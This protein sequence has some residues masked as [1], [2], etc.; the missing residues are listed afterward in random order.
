MISSE[1]DQVTSVTFNSDTVKASPEGGI[2]ALLLELID[3]VASYTDC[4]DLTV[5]NFMY[6]N[7]EDSKM[8]AALAKAKC[9]IFK[10][11]EFL[12]CRGRFH[13]KR[14]TLSHEEI[15]AKDSPDFKENDFVAEL[16]RLVAC[17]ILAV[18]KGLPLIMLNLEVSEANAIASSLTKKTCRHVYWYKKGSPENNFGLVSHHTHEIIIKNF[19]TA[20]VTATV[21]SIAAGLEPYNEMHY[22]SD[23]AAIG[24]DV[25]MSN[26]GVGVLASFNNQ[27]LVLA[28]SFGSDSKLNDFTRGL[29]AKNYLRLLA[30][31]DMSGDEYLADITKATHIAI[32]GGALGAA[33]GAYRLGRYCG[34]VMSNFNISSILEV[35]PTRLKKIITGYGFADKAA[36]KKFA[37]YKLNLTGGDFLNEDES[38]ALALLYCKINES[39][40]E[41][42]LAKKRAKKKP[43]KNKAAKNNHD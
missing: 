2:D 19:S 13:S 30:L 22:I 37:L 5:A 39:G 12:N 24:L 3:A 41:F 7:C 34:M 4:S 31:K 38:D 6:A 25:S 40:L 43:P 23:I 29:A 35:A 20:A 33:H 16:E 10:L 42:S 36:V 17:I 18:K 28:G 11:P 15:K 27:D 14:Y 1:N 8:L 21:V 32:E 9:V 26:T